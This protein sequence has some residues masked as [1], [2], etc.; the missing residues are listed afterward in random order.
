M[1]EVPT[2]SILKVLAWLL[3]QPGVVDLLQE[4]LR[5][6]TEE[7]DPAPPGPLVVHTVEEVAKI[8]RLSRTG[9]YEM[10]QT[11]QIPSIRLGRAIRVPDS[12]L[13]LMHL[14]KPNS[15]IEGVQRETRAVHE[16]PGNPPDEARGNPAKAVA[17]SR[18][19]KE[20]SPLWGT[21]LIAKKLRMSP[22][23]VAKL[24][25]SGHIYTFSSG[26]RRV[27]HEWQLD[28]YLRLQGKVPEDGWERHFRKIAYQ[29][30][31]EADK[32]AAV[33]D[34]FNPKTGDFEDLNA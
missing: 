22:G 16:P 11:G 21:M 33:R 8:L 27:C 30:M 2:D 25:R 10:I 31:S 13:A 28:E 5:V 34:G 15:P 9:A 7:R 14:R 4:K 29:A 18:P 19:V 20:P 26:S 12:A 24:I 32:A 3:E 6:V 17:G 1:A 23:Q